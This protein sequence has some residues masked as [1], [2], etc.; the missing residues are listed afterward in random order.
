[1]KYFFVPNRVLR[2]TSCH[3]RFIQTYL[4]A[5]LRTCVSILLPTKVV[6]LRLRVIK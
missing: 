4:K 1:M 2:E 3:F 6:L 5:M